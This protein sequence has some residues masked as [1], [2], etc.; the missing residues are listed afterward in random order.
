M[1]GKSPPIACD[2]FGGPYIQVQAIF[3]S[4]EDASGPNK[5]VF[6]MRLPARRGI[7]LSEGNA[8]QRS[9]WVAGGLNRKGPTGGDA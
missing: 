4:R 2:G 3:A 8:R 1:T 9:A 5:C 7:G 6:G